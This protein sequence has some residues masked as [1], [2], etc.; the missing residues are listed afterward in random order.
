MKDKAPPGRPVE[1]TAPE[2]IEKIH[3]I[4]MEDRRIKVREIAE[5]VG[6][7]VGTVHNILHEKLEMRNMCARWM[8]R[9]L[10][11][12]QKRTRKDISEQC[13]IM[14]KRNVQDFWRRFV[15]VDET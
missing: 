6:I 14:L 11:I 12:G 8:P 5:I 4:A 1:A 10:N 7:S 3:R 15:T 13:L 2:M 9:L